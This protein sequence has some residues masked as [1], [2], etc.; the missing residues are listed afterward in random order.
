M[1]HCAKQ[2]LSS[3]STTWTTTFGLRPAMLIEAGML[4]L[5]LHLA[6]CLFIYN[7]TGKDIIYT[8]PP[9]RLYLGRSRR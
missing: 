1:P 8:P 6:R 9:N 7:S 2:W 5:M 3:N 4:G